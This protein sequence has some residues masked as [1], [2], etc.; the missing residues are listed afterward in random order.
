MIIVAILAAASYTTGSY[1]S[2]NKN[3]LNFGNIYGVS[4]LM[5]YLNYL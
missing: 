5:N 1:P 4:A 3:D 2:K